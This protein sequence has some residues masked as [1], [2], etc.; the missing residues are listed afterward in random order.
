MMATTPD[1]LHAKPAP[2][3]RPELAIAIATVTVIA[4]AVTQPGFLVGMFCSALA[5][6]AVVNFDA[7][8]CAL[9]FLLPWYPFIDW[10]F[11]LHD[12]FLSTRFLIFGVVAV[13]QISLGIPL[14]SWLWEGWLRKAVWLFAA[15]EIISLAISDYRTVSATYPSLFKQL[16]YIAMFFGIA[17]WADSREKIRRILQIVLIS[18]IAVCLFGLYQSFVGGFTDL[19]FR[20]YPRME[21]AY[22]SLGGWKGRIT[23]F[24]FH[25]NSL[26]GYLNTVGP[27]ALGMAVLGKERWL[28]ATGFVCLALVGAAQ[29]LTYS[30][31]GLA[32]CGAFAFVCIC[33]LKPRRKTIAVLLIASILA[34]GLGLS[35]EYLGDLRSD[36]LKDVDD[37]TLESRVALWG[38]ATVIFLQ[39]PVLGAGVGTFRYRFHPYVPGIVQ[40]LDAHNLYLQTLAET[41][42]VGFL[43][44][45]VAMWGFFRRGVRLSKRKD[46]L[47]VVVGVG[48]AGALAALMAHG[49]VDYIFLVS[50]QFGGLFWMLM[51]LGTA[52]NEVMA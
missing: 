24:L 15:T 41:G 27:L 4:L 42:V 32:G 14:R 26:A 38:A 9:V 3:Y 51:G 48:V 7:F 25:Y 34:A 46:E 35:L 19:F 49:L 5:L 2:K 1:A 18:T 39:N 33:W 12:V 23:S 6:T 28:R 44:F 52:A 13:R 40:D 36:R 20:M 45:F 30:R 8:V 11:P 43:I 50:P 37:F 16:S 17:G 29:Y 22:E 21:E 31:G 47:G 10:N